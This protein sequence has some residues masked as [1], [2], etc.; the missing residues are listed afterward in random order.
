MKFDKLLDT[1]D[2][3]DDILEFVQEIFEIENPTIRSLLSN[4]LLN[5]FYFP[6]VVKSISGAID[7]PEPKRYEVSISTA[8]FVLNRTFK[9]IS[10]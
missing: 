1:I 4:A 6:V 8:L 10:F 3:M 2:D 7:C 9:L 5:Y